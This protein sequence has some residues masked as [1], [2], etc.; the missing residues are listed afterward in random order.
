[1][2]EVS[3]LFLVVC[4]ER[5]VKCDRLESVKFREMRINL[6]VGLDRRELF[7]LWDY[8][9]CVLGGLLACG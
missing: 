5:S 4:A 1:M 8:V 7:V 6:G 2:W 9:V 3:R